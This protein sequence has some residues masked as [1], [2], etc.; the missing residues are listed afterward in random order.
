M[1]LQFPGQIGPNNF[2]MMPY[3][4]QEFEDYCTG[5]ILMAA[6]TAKSDFQSTYASGAG[7][8]WSPAVQAEVVQSQPQSTINLQSQSAGALQN[9]MDLVSSP[10]ISNEAIQTAPR[11]Y[12]VGSPQA[13]SPFTREQTGMDGQRQNW[14]DGLTIQGAM[15]NKKKRSAP[16]GRLPGNC[17]VPMENIP[18]PLWGTPAGRVEAQPSGWG[19][20]LL[21]AGLGL[22]GASL[23]ERK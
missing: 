14:P 18:G 5:E 19:K 2:E 11:V 16:G 9:M 22:I 17:G 7:L 10:I 6:E 20:L 13:L 15:A 21:F 1:A 4:D 3:S 8:S 23:L 12:P